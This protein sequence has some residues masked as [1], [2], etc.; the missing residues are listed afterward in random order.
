MEKR[1][2]KIDKKDTKKEIVRNGG[3]EK[4]RRIEVM[5]VRKK[6]KHQK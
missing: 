4:S 1:R 5:K 3:K 2:V 6:N